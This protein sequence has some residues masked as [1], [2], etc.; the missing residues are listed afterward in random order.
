[1]SMRNIL[2]AFIILAFTVLAHAQD[3]GAERNVERAL[4]DPSLTTP[5]R[6]SAPE[7]S[8]NINEDQKT[9]KLQYGMKVDFEKSWALTL[10]G[11]LSEE[12]DTTSL[13]TLD[14]L[15]NGVNA[16]LAFSR[17][18]HSSLGRTGSEIP[19]LSRAFSDICLRDTGNRNCTLQ[20]LSAT[21]QNVVLGTFGPTFRY[22]GAV[23]V[24]H[25][26]FEYFDTAANS[27]TVTRNGW[28][29]SASAGYFPPGTVPITLLYY[30]NMSV[31][32]ESAYKA[33]DDAQS[34]TPVTGST[35]NQCKT[36]PFGPPT[37]ARSTI[38]QLDLRQFPHD[39][40]ALAPR[41]R[42]TDSTDK[43]KQGWSFALPVYIRQ[44]NDGPF[45]GGI[46]LDWDTQH[47]KFGVSL[48]VGALGSL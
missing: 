42:Y 8:F 22:G 3:T 17:T 4:V 34:C 37:N 15:D 28:S 11:P 2:V 39:L 13:A 36:L 31:K 12:N 26:S 45:N 18:I 23:K 16:E 38:A 5:N 33:A 7:L 40:I 24:G 41:A 9:V 10:S 35:V 46:S 14:G 48:F 29:A 27:Q 32:R 1:M 6:A 30:A 19:L 43:T 44:K 25:K 47:K 20:K 21:A